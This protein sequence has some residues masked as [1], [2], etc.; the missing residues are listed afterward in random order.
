MGTSHPPTTACTLEPTGAVP[1][2]LPPAAIQC[3]RCVSYVTGRLCPLED[4]RSREDGVGRGRSDAGTAAGE[5]GFPLLVRCG[6]EHGVSG[7]VVGGHGGAGSG[8]AP[9]A[10]GMNPAVASFPLGFEACAI[11][12]LTPPLVSTHRRHGQQTWHTVLAAPPS[13]ESMSPAV[14]TNARL[15]TLS[16]GGELWQATRS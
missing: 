7:A 8:V 10:A 2:V 9:A 1:A 4:R 15:H 5:M 3:R 6:F 12:L 13:G 14:F 11:F 16:A